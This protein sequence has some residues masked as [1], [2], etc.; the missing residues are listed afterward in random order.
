MGKRCSKCNTVKDHSAFGSREGGRLK[1]WCQECLNTA[2]KVRSSSPQVKDRL[3]RYHKM[4]NA[5]LRLGCLQH[6]SNAAIPVCKCCGVTTLV[7]LS[8]DHIKND[9]NI[10]RKQVGSNLYRWL[11][12]NSYPEGYQVLCMNCQFS[13]RKHLIACLEHVP[14]ELIFDME[15]APGIRFGVCNG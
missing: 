2:S 10:H 1:S 7:F 4:D 11:R 15:Q 13:K 6:Y 12:D 5:G 9:G 14:V 3:S 8:I